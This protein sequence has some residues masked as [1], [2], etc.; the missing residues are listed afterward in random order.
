MVEKSHGSS[1]TSRTSDQGTTKGAK[2]PDC[3][4]SHNSSAPEAQKISQQI[5]QKVILILKVLNTTFHGF[6]I[7]IIIK[8]LI[9]VYIIINILIIV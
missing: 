1:P 3:E 7:Y 8:I 6:T 4:I 9:I 2:G 5:S